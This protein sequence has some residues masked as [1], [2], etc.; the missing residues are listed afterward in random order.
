MLTEAEQEEMLETL[1][2]TEKP[3]QALARALHDLAW[4]ALDAALDHYAA[5]SLRANTP[6]LLAFAVWDHTLRTAINTHQNILAVA[7]ENKE[8]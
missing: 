2:I 5:G 1:G 7:R 8:N 3:A 4:S 6:G